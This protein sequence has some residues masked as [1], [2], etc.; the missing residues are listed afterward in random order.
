[1]S[2][3]EDILRFLGLLEPAPAADDGFVTRILVKIVDS[4]ALNLAQSGTL[5]LD[6]LAAKAGPAAAG[7][8]L[9]AIKEIA[10][11]IVFGRAF[12]S[13]S[14]LEI[15]AV[16]NAARAEDATYEPFNF[17]NALEI[18][19]TGDFDTN[20][21]EAALNAWAGV[22]EYAYTGAEPSDPAVAA[23]PNPLFSLQGYLAAAPKGIDAKA[24]WNKGADGTNTA[25]IDLEQGWFLT[26]VDLPSPIALVGG[27]NS[28]KSF[29]HGV[30]VLGIIVALDDT[31][32]IV[33]IAP[34]AG[35]RVISYVD[36]V[37][38]S[39]KLNS[40]IEDRVLKAAALLALG[41][42][43]QLEVQLIGRVLSGGTERTF[44]PAEIEPLVFAAIRVATAKGI[45]VV[46]A[47][48][49]GGN[50][51]NP[52]THKIDH[53][54]TDLDG[55]VDRSGKK[56]LSRSTPSEFQDSGAIMVSGSISAVPHKPRPDLNFGS[57]IDCYAWG[58]DIVTSGWDSQLPNARDLYFGIGLYT[59]TP[60]GGTSGACPIITGSCLL[61]QHLQSV[62]KPNGRPAGAVSGAVMRTIMSTA[63]NGTAS[64]ATTD[65]IGVMPDFAKLIVNE[66]LP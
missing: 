9:D 25:F 60:F 49:N 2:V 4:V 24:A 19:C 5:T 18:V 20:A 47:A 10:P 3:I 56:V 14:P 40:R 38:S 52:V 53:R 30:A 8:A 35:V 7:S 46:E 59:T 48:G 50:Y 54:G 34:K 57:R 39:R 6:E 36:P 45:V 41:N 16:V 1:M 22:V 13:L 33:G 58:D 28:R 17:E 15:Q 27:V 26:H 31:F 43:L 37:A 63:S 44:L 61:F 29:L 62:L 55:Y 11:G 51:R 42:V 23:T 21:L 66:F 65:K 12:D 64:A 32:G